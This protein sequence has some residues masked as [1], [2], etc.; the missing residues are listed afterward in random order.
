MRHRRDEGSC[1]GCRVSGVGGGDRRIV[2]WDGYRWGESALRVR[3]RLH[4][5]Y[6]YKCVRAI[7]HP[8]PPSRG[9][10]NAPKTDFRVYIMSSV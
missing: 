8:E 10:G 5:I 6:T 4:Y 3:V 1:G 9:C 7:R 2:V